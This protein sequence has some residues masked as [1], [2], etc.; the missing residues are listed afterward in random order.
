MILTNS[1]PSTPLS[2][3]FR[4]LG[5]S[6][7]DVA[8]PAMVLQSS[9]QADQVG[10]KRTQGT[11]ML[12]TG[13]LYTKGRY[14]QKVDDDLNYGASTFIGKP[15]QMSLFDPAALPE[16][17][18]EAIRPLVHRGSVVA[19]EDYEPDLLIFID[20]WVQCQNEE[21][22]SYLN[23]PEEAKPPTRIVTSRRAMSV[24]YD[25]FGDPPASRGESIALF[26]LRPTARWLYDLHQTR[27]RLVLR[28]YIAPLS[29]NR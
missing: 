9:D 1:T 10:R 28:E 13:P 25:L 4:L 3:T 17:L 11:K 8:S 22:R 2:E 7:R 24:I 23:A 12:K 21:F 18:V 6:T 26:A 14:G 27:P 15:C 29:G 20:C 19:S 5:L 16:L